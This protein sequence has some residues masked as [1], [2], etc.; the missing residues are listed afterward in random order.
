MVDPDSR[1]SGEGLKALQ[2]AGIEV[3]LADGEEHL[4]CQQANAAYVHRILQG[5]PLVT[6]LQGLTDACNQLRE[7]DEESQS[8]YLNELASVLAGPLQDMDSLLVTDLSSQDQLVACRLLPV[9]NIIICTAGM[10]EQEVDAVS[11]LL[12]AGRRVFMLSPAEAL[13]SVGTAAASITEAKLTSSGGWKTVPSQLVCNGVV[14]LSSSE[15]L[16]VSIQRSVQLAV[17]EE[18]THDET[19]DEETSPIAHLRKLMLPV[20][21]TSRIITLQGKRLRLSATTSRQ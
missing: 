14:C 9:V 20:S 3:L 8:Y 6:A 2:T 11:R 4:L 21:A 10:D 5:R 1:V 17:M 18:A 15:G 16:F 7:L 13:R 12:Q 19:E